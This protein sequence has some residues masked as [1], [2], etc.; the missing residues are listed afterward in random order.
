[1]LAAIFRRWSRTDGLLWD[2]SEGNVGEL[3]GR[4]ITARPVPLGYAPLLEFEVLPR[5]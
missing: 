3:A 4:G 1:M 5:I 2:Y